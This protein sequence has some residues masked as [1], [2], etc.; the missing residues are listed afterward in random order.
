M[1]SKKKRVYRFVLVCFT[2]FFLSQLISIPAETR[3][4][5]ENLYITYPKTGTLFPPEFPPPTI[6]WEDDSES[7]DT[8]S[9]RV[10]L[11]G[12]LAPFR[13]ETAKTK[14]RPDLKAWETIKKAS[15]NAD[16]VIQIAGF[17]SSHP[18]KPVSAGSV[19]IRTSTDKVGAPILYRDVPLPFIYGVKNP[20]TISW[21]LGY[22]DS[23]E[24]SGLVLENLPVCGNCHSVSANGKVLGMDVDYASDKGSYAL[25]EIEKTTV[26]SPKNVITWSDFRRG[27]GELT[28]GL[29]SQVSPSG[30][31]AVST[32]K[33]RSV[34][35]PIDNLAYSQLFFPVKGILAVY[36]RVEKSFQALPG[37]DD[38]DYVQSNPVWSPDGKTIYF[39]RSEGIELEGIDKIKSILLPPDLVQDFIT[40]KQGFQYDIYRVSF[41]NG[42][43]GTAEPVAGA[44]H[45]GKSNY[46]PRISPDGQWLVFTQAENFML[47]QKDSELYI[48]PAKGGK[49]RKMQC[50]TS[51]MNSWHAWSPNSRWL[52]FAAKERGPYTQLYLTHVDENGRDSP[53]VVLEYFQYDGRAANIPEFV[54]VQ[55]GAFE[56]ISAEFIDDHNYV[57]QGNELASF[58]GDYQGAVEYF[59][60]AI[61]IN[62]KNLRAHTEL[63]KALVMTGKFKEAEA[64]FK[65][66]LEKD[67]L[68]EE[69]L[70]SIGRFYLSSYRYQAAETIYQKLLNIHPEHIEAN[71]NY[72][73]TLFNLGKLNEAAG[74]FKK[75]LTIEPENPV[76]HLY[77]GKTLEKLGKPEE[78]DRHFVQALNFP[79]TAQIRDCVHVAQHLMHI[80]KYQ[81]RIIELMETALKSPVEK[82]EPYVIIG[83][84]KLRQGDIQGAIKAF[85]SARTIKNCPAWVSEKID[86]L[87]QQ[88]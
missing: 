47:L 54:N 63:G 67:L 57:R 5:P 55:K 49:P 34:F 27:D 65:T 16:A 12:V 26:I 32:V 28:F 30:R 68:N 75:T 14:W 25:T 29:L 45:N 70:T 80:P 33:D 2:I 77:L 78:A 15:V 42:K 52:V 73:L 43:G 83:K 72:G 24:P 6:I 51:N 20:E 31:Y 46:F 88:L 10:K 79:V 13:A 40:G 37:A 60:K 17:S 22:P 71:I 9:I 23:A 18:E 85:E 21:K 59:K 53:P 76:A 35:V 64:R 81:D 19:A 84:V 56:T 11:K 86:E 3:N 82:G 44:S 50:N 48:M 87:K 66:V 39:A 69:A 38:P 61:E 1:N 36:D 4:N 41:N 74:R 58:H 8:W 7:V 62:P